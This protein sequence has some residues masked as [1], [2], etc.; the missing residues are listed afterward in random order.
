MVRVRPTLVA[1]ALLLS[2]APSAYAMPSVSLHAFVPV[3]G[4][5]FQ[6][7]TAAT[8]WF[9]PTARGSVIVQVNA[10]DPTGISHVDF[11]SLGPGWSEGGR[12]RY[13]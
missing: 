3:T 9:N 7:S 10:A 5:G 1:L 12:E 6:A 4:S 2:C 8:M 13:H 11:P